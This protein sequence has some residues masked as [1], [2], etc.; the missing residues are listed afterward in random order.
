VVLA[1]VGSTLDVVHE[2]AAQGAPAGTV[3]LADQ[4]LEGRGREGRRWHSPPGQGVL[5]GYLHRPAGGCAVGVLALRVGLAVAEGLTALGFEPKLKWPNDLVI[6]GRKAGGV[7]C[8]ARTAPGG[9][10][11]VAVGVGI[12]VRGPLPAEVAE[13]AVALDQAKPGITRVAVLEAVIPRLHRLPAGGVLSERE[14]AAYRR[15][16]W[17]AG[18]MLQ[19]PVRGRA[20]GVDPSGALMVETDGGCQ[21]LWAGTVVASDG[22]PLEEAPASGSAGLQALDR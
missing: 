13:R 21:R 1:A 10:S 15:L 11:W 7:L 12:N 20:R 3:V 16:D 19:Q 2:L 6:A 8:E 4:Q 9:T 22:A 17:L 5:V 18:R 14:L